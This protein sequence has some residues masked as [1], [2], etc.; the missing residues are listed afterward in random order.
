MKKLSLYGPFLI[1][2]AF[3]A[4][5]LVCLGANTDYEPIIN[6]VAGGGPN[7]VPALSANI[8]RPVAVAM[9]STGNFYIASSSQDSVFKVDISGQLTVAVGTGNF[10]FWFQY[11][12]DNGP[13]TEAAL[14]SPYDVLVDT[15]NNLFI[16]D[17][18]MNCIRKVDA[19]TGIIT[20]V[21]G[22]GYLMGSYSGDGGPALNARMNRPNGIALDSSGNLFIADSS[23]ARIRKV[24]KVT[25]I[26]TTVVGTGYYTG[27]L[28]GEGGD[29]LDDL[30]DGGPA[31]NASLNSPMG[32]DFDSN[33]NL[34]IADSFNNRIRKVD[35]TTSIITTVAGTGIR[36]YS[37]DN[38]PATSAKLYYPWKI[39]CDSSG[40]IF[41]ADTVNRRIRKVDATT[42]IITTV[43]GGGNPPYPDIGDGG[44]ATDARLYPYDI[45]VDFAGNLFITDSSNNRLRKVDASTGIIT[46]VAGNGEQM[47]GGDGEL[48]TNASLYACRDVAV[49]AAGN[50]FIC[51]ANSGRI[52]RVD[53]TTRII[54]TVAGGGNPPYPDIGDGGPAT[55]ARLAQPWGV[56]LDSDGNLFI[57]EQGHYRVRKVESLTNII[58]TV[59]GT[60]ISQGSID[61]EGGDPRDD[62]GDY[63]PATSASF[64]RADDVALDSS[65]NLYI[66]DF[67][68]HRIRKVD[69]VSGI[70]TTV[71]GTGIQT[72]T[73]DGE[74]GNPTDDLG[75]GGPASN[76]T[77]AYPSR[78]SFDTD[79]NLYI[80]DTRGYRI[81][82]VDTTTGIITTVAGTGRRGYSGDGG[83]ATSARLGILTAVHVDVFHNIYISSETRVR[84]VD[85]V[86]GIIDR[87]A[88]TGAWAFGG[89][90][91]P[92]KEAWL[93]WPY[94]LNTDQY[95]NLYIADSQFYRI[96]KVTFKLTPEQQIKKLIDDMNRLIIEG[97]IAPGKK[98]K[99]MIRK[100]NEA[101]TAL[102]RGNE[103]VACNKLHDFIDQVNAA[104]NADPLTEEEGQVL[105]DAAIALIDELCGS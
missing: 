71:A 75:D 41:I 102:G 39:T 44:P 36:G 48:A 78:I 22:R 67:L 68:D 10:T 1:V 63:G 29:P 43:A 85:G 11:A 30:G 64:K 32:V 105:I 21:A 40:N 98:D 62:L 88:G 69:V 3:F 97:K 65:R 76:A 56:I 47:F 84:R 12:G 7:N 31:T 57:S 45:L 58:S 93:C 79:D 26:I 52:R 70:I 94:G 90:G 95:G 89:D 49:D 77:L 53:A 91:G 19:T 16:A 4:F 86:T 50:L 103:R 55:D 8:A 14:W 34:L 80:C 20:S 99:G 35:K 61:G 101:L 59:A 17:T 15:Y 51:D 81:R 96:R 27:Q 60:G 82:K 104:I 92:A 54:T 13:A 72:G 33:G 87:V 73:I 46:T 24:D 18:M 83:P 74:G 25:G 38:G 66:S 42:G 9:D 5:L 2:L 6:T 37:G 23:N 28:D 100:L